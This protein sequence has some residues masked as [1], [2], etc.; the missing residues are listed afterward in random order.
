MAEFSLDRGIIDK[1]EAA[2]NYRLRL[3]FMTEHTPDTFN[4]R[5]RVLLLTDIEVL[6]P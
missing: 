2:E 5:L 3:K 1:A 4:L 6:S